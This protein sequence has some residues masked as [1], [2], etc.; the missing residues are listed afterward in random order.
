MK[1]VE[2]PLCRQSIPPM[3]GAVEQMC[4]DRNRK[5]AALRRYAGDKND[6]D[7]HDEASGDQRCCC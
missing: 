2:V 4:Q 5:K 1:V 6:S 3:S 7:G